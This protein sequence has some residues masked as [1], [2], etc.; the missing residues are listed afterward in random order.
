MKFLAKHPLGRRITG[1]ILLV[2]II[3]S[4]MCVSA[5]AADKQFY[6]N[7]SNTGT[8]SYVYSDTY[9]TKAYA[10]SNATIKVNY[11]NAP[12]WGYRLTLVN[13]SY[14]PSTYH[15]WFSSAGTDHPA[16]YSGYATVGMNYYMAGRIDNDYS[17]T[18]TTYGYFNSDYT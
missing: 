10:N 15:H 2:M 1:I 7:M 12:G 14:H 8:T 16:Y 3:A 11:V 13:S 5:F 18:Y 4:V 17:G 9:N 6:F